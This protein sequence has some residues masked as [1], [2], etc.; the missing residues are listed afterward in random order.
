MQ[1]FCS[2]CN[3]TK[4]FWNFSMPLSLLHPYEEEKPKYVILMHVFRGREGVGREDWSVMVLWYLSAVLTEELKGQNMACKAKT[5]SLQ[6]VV[7]WLKRFKFRNAQMMMM[8]MMFVTHH[9]YWLRILLYGSYGTNK[10]KADLEERPFPSEVPVYSSC[11]NM[12]QMLNVSSLFIN[13][14][15]SFYLSI[16]LK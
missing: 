14:S 9:T 2:C 6:I 1:K 12:H 3:M 16:A 5:L 7:F 8:M 10:T 15:S 4:V 11:F 13:F